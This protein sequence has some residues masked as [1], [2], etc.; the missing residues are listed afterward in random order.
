[1]EEGK[2]KKRRGRKGLENRAREGEEKE[3][4]GRGGSKRRDSWTGNKREVEKS[5][6]AEEKILSKE[7]KRR[8]R[9]RSEEE[10]KNIA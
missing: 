7:G 1:M 6:R 3:E 2:K 4:E 5:I 8:E 9:K 10:R